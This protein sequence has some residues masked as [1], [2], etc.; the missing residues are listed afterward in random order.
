[1][2]D[3]PLARLKALSGVLHEFP[4]LTSDLLELA[5]WM[6]QYY[7]ARM[8]AVLEA[9]IPAAVRDGAHLKSEKYLEVTRT[10]SPDEHT[11]LAKK[12]P[13]QAKLYDFLKQ[14]F[15]PQK[16]S[17]VLSRLGATAAVVTHWSR[18]A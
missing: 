13:K 17:L 1:V 11:A 9:M 18:T 7:A 4:A 3:V 10:L 6:H 16:K 15:Q 8:E 5:R 2:P 14:Q 12:A